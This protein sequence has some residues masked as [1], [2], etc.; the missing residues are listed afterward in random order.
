[1][2]VHRVVGSHGLW[3]LFWLLRGFKRFLDRRCSIELPLSRGKDVFVMLE[4]GD[5][6]GGRHVRLVAVGAGLV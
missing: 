5:L 4:V 3:Q 6:G 1:M 2:E